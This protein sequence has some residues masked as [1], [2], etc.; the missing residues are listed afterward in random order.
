MFSLKTFLWFTL[1]V[2]V[3]AAIFFV[4]IICTCGIDGIFTNLP[5]MLKDPEHPQIGFIAKLKGFCVD[6]IALLVLFHRHSLLSRTVD[7]SVIPPL[8]RSASQRGHL[9]EI[10]LDQLGIDA[11]LP[12]D[13]AVEGCAGLCGAL[14]GL[15][16]DPVQAEGGLEA[17]PFK[18]VQHGPIQIAA[19]V[20]TEADRL[21]DRR[22]ILCQKDDA[23][24]V[25]LAGNAVFGDIDGL[26]AS[27]IAPR[28]P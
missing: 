26:T 3:L 20:G 9:R 5:L 17:A 12:D 23:E 21:L 22:Q 16:I 10:L 13:L 1:G 6:K 18:V 24:S 4:F 7:E 15:E 19:H 11:V 14:K 8:R 2:S 28:I 25:I 27:N